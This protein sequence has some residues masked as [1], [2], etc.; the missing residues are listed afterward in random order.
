VNE[1]INPSELSASQSEEKIAQKVLIRG[2]TRA[3]VQLS[4]KIVIGLT[5]I[6]VVLIVGAFY[7][8]MQQRQEEQEQIKNL[9]G[10]E[11]KAKAEAFNGLP[12]DYSEI[13]RSAPRIGP[14]LP[15][16][17]GRP[18]LNAGVLPGA[19]I[20]AGAPVDP[21]IQRQNQEIEAAR[22]SRL[23]STTNVRQASGTST[24][25]SQVVGSTAGNA[26]QSAAFAND[27]TFAQSGQDR[28]LAFVNA[29]GD[30]KAVSNHRL[31]PAASPFI[32]QAGTIIP[33]SLL[34]GIRSDLPGEITAQV[35]EQV[36]DSPTGQALLIPQGSRLIGSYDSQVAFGQSR[37]LLV[38]TRLILPNGKSILLDRQKGADVAGYSGLEDEVDN[39]WGALFKAAAVSTLLSVGSQVAVGN[40]TNQ[41][42]Q[43]MAQ[44]AAL[45]FNQIGRQIIGRNLNIQPTL[46]IRPGFPVRVI[47]NRDLVLEPYKTEG[48]SNE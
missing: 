27:E 3:V 20:G 48:A 41:L 13:S 22:V 42:Q 2:E 10:A 47:V 5:C 45:G 12:K 19:S 25:P 38:W 23:F 35:T 24:G 28:K 44:G 33:G 7:L 1:P 8:G 30:S 9:I 36:Y 18:M 46:T 34:T 17:L 43:A 21:E 14:P 29:A 31:Q 16:D 11:Q 15:G 37:V 39:H 4:R 26:S 40:S 32:I 6:A